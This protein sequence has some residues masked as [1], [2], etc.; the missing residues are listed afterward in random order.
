MKVNQIAVTLY[1]VRDFCQNEKDLLESLKKSKILDIAAFK[2]AEL[3][4]LILK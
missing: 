2:S 1:T 3:V 4:H